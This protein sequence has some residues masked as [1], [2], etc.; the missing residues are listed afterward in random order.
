MILG[1]SLWRT[2]C[3]LEESSKGKTFFMSSKV[4]KKIVALMKNLCLRL[5]SCFSILL[6]T[7]NDIWRSNFFWIC[8]IY[9][10]LFTY[11]W[12][13]WWGFFTEHASWK[14]PKI[15]REGISTC[16]ARVSFI[17]LTGGE[18]I[19]DFCFSFFYFIF[20]LSLIPMHWE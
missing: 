18:N 12:C 17:S 7:L 20:Y 1:S 10:Q 11:S 13:H 14:Q 9:L 15:I 4:K 5:N 2:D 16:I 8:F 19:F 3:C 6:S